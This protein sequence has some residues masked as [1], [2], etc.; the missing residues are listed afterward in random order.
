MS[1]CWLHK[2]AEKVT[3]K[4]QERILIK[5]AI[6][7]RWRSSILVYLSGPNMNFRFT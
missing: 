2:K 6:L 1:G 3:V 5:M 4:R 7:G